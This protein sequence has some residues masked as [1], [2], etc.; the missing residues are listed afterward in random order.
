[1][2]WTLTPSEARKVVRRG[3]CAACTGRLVLLSHEDGTCTVGCFSCG[4]EVAVVAPDAVAPY[5]RD[6][7]P[8]P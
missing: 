1:M 3:R 2:A 8:R 7:D 6:P 5:W 4:R